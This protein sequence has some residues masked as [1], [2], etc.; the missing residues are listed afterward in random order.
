MVHFRVLL[1]IY[2]KYCAVAEK[3][4]SISLGSWKISIFL[5]SVAYIFLLKIICR[6]SHATGE[7]KKIL[8]QN[9]YGC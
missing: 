2:Q 3:F 7:A 1:I 5:K 6:C 9:M 8:S 4:I